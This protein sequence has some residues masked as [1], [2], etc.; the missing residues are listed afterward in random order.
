MTYTALPIFIY[1]LWD[2]EYDP[3]H[4]IANPR[5]YEKGI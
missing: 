5:L 2:E 4:L 3:K 1:A